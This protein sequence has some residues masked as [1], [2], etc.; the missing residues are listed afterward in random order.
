MLGKRHEVS[1]TVQQPQGVTLMGWVPMWVRAAALSGKEW[2]LIVFE[3]MGDELLKMNITDAAK[4]LAQESKL[5]VGSCKNLLRATG[6][7]KKKPRGLTKPRQRF[8]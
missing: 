7:W 6:F 8:K 1:I 4:V 5:A 3:R 2:F